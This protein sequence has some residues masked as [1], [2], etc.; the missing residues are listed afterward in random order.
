MIQTASEIDS[1]PAFVV[2]MVLRRAPEET[3]QAVRRTSFSFTLVGVF[4]ETN[5][6]KRTSF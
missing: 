6:P 2:N 5:T 4:V 1:E 3:K